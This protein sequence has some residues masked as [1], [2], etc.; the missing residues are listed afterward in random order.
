MA[1]TG[2]PFC[3]H[4]KLRTAC[5]VCKAT[6]APLPTSDLRTI[7][8]ESQVERLEKAEKRNARFAALDRRE[9]DPEASPARKAGTPGGPGRP[10]LPK[11]STKRGVTAADEARAEA[12][13]VKKG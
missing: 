10:L 1:A 5:A 12:W 4:K 6:G 2:S 9:P 8:Y 7:P 11:R 13:W 3:E